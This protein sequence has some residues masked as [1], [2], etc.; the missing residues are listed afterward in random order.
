MFISRRQTTSSPRA[1]Q[2]LSKFLS[3]EWR[4]FTASQMHRPCSTRKFPVKTRHPP[5]LVGL[6]GSS[7]SSQFLF[8]LCS[9][10]CCWLFTNP[11]RSHRMKSGMSMTNGNLSILF[12]L[13]F[14]RQ[15]CIVIISRENEESN[16]LKNGRALTL[17]FT[18]LSG[19]ITLYPKY[20]STRA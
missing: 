7:S 1:Y 18:L 2:L 13:L 11:F 9:Y 3:M 8:L 19:A 15:T 14:R 10:Y 20:S 16:F 12:A 5:R 4:G 6:K 17:S